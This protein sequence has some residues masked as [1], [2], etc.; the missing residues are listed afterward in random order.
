MIFFVTDRCNARCKHC[1]NWD[2][3]RDSK[4][5]EE[6]S[7]EEIKKISSHFGRIKYMTYGG[8]EP[9]YARGYSRHNQ[10]FL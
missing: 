7:L 10:N 5:T 6:L 9:R 8:G 4:S 1:F 3:I 2:K